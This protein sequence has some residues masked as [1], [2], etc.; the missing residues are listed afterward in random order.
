MDFVRGHPTLIVALAAILRLVVPAI[1]KLAG[2][3]D[4]NENAISHVYGQQTICVAMDF[5]GW[6]EA[7]SASFFVAGLMDAF[8]F[9]QFYRIV[10]LPSG[11]EEV[12]KLREGL[13]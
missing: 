3:V 6:W 9:I 2:N 4:P 11:E 13:L 10:R 8:A 1:A 5:P 12:P 7:A